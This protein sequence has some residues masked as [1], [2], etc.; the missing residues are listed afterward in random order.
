MVVGEDDVDDLRARVRDERIDMSGGGMVIAD[1]ALPRDVLDAL[2]AAY[3]TVTARRTVFPYAFAVPAGV[4]RD[5]ALNMGCTEV[6]SPWGD[7]IAER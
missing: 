2:G 1:M 4:L 7:A 3:R 5:G 6:M